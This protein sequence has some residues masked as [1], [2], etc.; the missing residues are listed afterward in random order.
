MK[1]TL[2]TS[3]CIMTLCM[4][5]T[6]C[7]PS[8]E[9]IVEAENA[10]AS[11]TAAH[12]AAEEKYLDIADTSL[13]SELDQLGVQ[14]T[15][16]QNM[17]LTKSTNK[18]IDEELL[19][20]ITELIESYEVVQAKLDG[21]YEEEQEVITEQAKNLEISAYIINKTG[22]DLSSIVLHDITR[23]VY[24][25]N[26][27]GDNETIASGYTLMGAVLE[28]Y[29]E[30]VSWEFLITDVDGTQ[31][32]IACDNLAGLSEDGVSIVLEYDQETGTG[33]VSFGGYFSS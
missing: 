1:K 23:D 26:F 12:D 27:I 7:R 16:I 32:S 14:V 5:L 11:L 25:D 15:E 20:Q 6:G 21:T 4:V 28:I 33:Q 10:I 13:R 18:K 19:P 29:A 9:K 31:Y 30:S 22:H 2:V 17:D 24:S 3:I 8:D